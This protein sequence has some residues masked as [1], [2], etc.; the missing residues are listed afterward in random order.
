MC[1]TYL[2]VRG[3]AENFHCDG[4]TRE[5]SEKE[6]KDSKSHFSVN[7]LRHQLKALL[8]TT[9]LWKF[10]EKG[11]FGER[12]AGRKGEIFTGESYK[13]AT[14]GFLAAG[15]NFTMSFF[16]DGFST[17][18]SSTSSMWTIMCTINE[19]TF[20]L[21]PRMLLLHTLWPARKPQRSDT[22]LIP[23][24]KEIISLGRDGVEWTDE[25]GAKRLSRV[26]ALLCFADAVARPFLTVMTQFNGKNGCG[27]CEHEGIMIAK[28]NGFTRVYPLQDPLPADRTHQQTLEYATA[29]ADEP[30]SRI[31]GVKGPTWLFLIP[32]FDVIENMIPDSMHSIFIGIVGQ[33]LDLW[34]LSSKNSPFHIE[35]EHFD[36]IVANVKVPAE[37]LK[38][39][40]LHSSKWKAHEKRNFLFFYSVPALRQLLPRKYYRHWLLLVNAIRL[41]SQKEFADEVI[42]IAYVLA[43]DFVL[44]TAKLYGMEQNSYNVHALIH[45]IESVKRWGATWAT[46]AFMFEGELGKLKKFYH[47]SKG[48]EKQ[49]FGHY[50]MRQKLR[51]YAARYIPFASEAIQ[52]L[53]EKMDGPIKPLSDLPNSSAALG[54][55]VSFQI[56]RRLEEALE[57]LLGRPICCKSS[58]SFRRTFFNG[59]LYCTAEYCRAQRRDNSVIVLRDSR[60]VRIMK[61]LEIS[62][63]CT[64]CT[65]DARECLVY[66]R[67]CSNSH[68]MFFG[69]VLPFRRLPP[70]PHQATDNYDLSSILQ[71]MPA[72]CVT[73]SVI[74]F[75]P[76]DVASKCICVTIGNF[77]YRVMVDV[78]LEFD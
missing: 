64:C 62:L 37:V 5:V 68:L 30:G 52:D 42:E 61:I 12:A 46:S 63:Q 66:S 38:L 55:G 45:V 17:A 11:K 28:G 50:L 40:R 76:C 43:N 26:R 60:T 27:H 57:S 58:V 77:T 13:A 14:E 16:A 72:N 75:R 8:E 2:G 78:R 65:D 24:V 49:I 41:V 53:Y 20:D 34:L 10:I 51:G 48:I 35:I 9:D 44:T 70:M 47:G 39:P 23:F 22:F 54:K 31:C 33:F 29:A 19:L 21:K 1:Q 25:T 71:F 36:D 67:V 73:S 59:K 74:A 4:C 15:D 7:P 18:K 56:D 69:E 6:C 32:G 3:D